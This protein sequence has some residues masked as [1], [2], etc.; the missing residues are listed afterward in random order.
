MDFSPHLSTQTFAWDLETESTA[1]DIGSAV[2]S[3][4]LLEVSAHPKPGLVTPLV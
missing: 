2:L 3:G 4:V 1:W